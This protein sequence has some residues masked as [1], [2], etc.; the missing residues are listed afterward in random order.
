M[1]HSGLP[2]KR[3]SAFGETIFTPRARALFPDPG[4]DQRGHVLAVSAGEKTSMYLPFAVLF[5]PYWAGAVSGSVVMDAGHLLM[6]PLMALA[7]VWRRDEY[8]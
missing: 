2:G 1:G 7:M 6:L 5:V 3:R 8:R 4:L